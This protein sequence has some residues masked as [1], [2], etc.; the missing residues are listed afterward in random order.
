MFTFLGFGSP[1]YSAS[2]CA[3][4]PSPRNVNIAFA[5]ND[6]LYPLVVQCTIVNVNYVKVQKSCN[7]T[8]TFMLIKTLLFYS[9]PLKIFNKV[10]VHTL[11]NKYFKKIAAE[12][13]G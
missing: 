13:C 6:Q 11:S 5:L 7:R 12:H 10:V 9:V 1:S 8:I 4:L 3:C 2:P